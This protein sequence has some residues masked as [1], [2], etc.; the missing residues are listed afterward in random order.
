MSVQQM[1]AKK[2]REFARISGL[3]ID[4]VWNRSGGGQIFEVRTKDDE[5]WLVN[6]QTGE[7]ELNPYGWHMTSCPNFRCLLCNQDIPRTERETH[8]HDET[9]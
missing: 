1:G 2:I 5:H 4:M 7:K 3:D 6:R 8:T 9:E